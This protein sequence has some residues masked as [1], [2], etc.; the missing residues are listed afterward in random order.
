MSSV[1]E[2][3][4][5][6]QA[7][8]HCTHFTFYPDLSRCYRKRGNSKTFKEGAVSGTAVYFFYCMQ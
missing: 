5:H 8:P 6:C 4:A 3:Q 2:C 1:A 7:L